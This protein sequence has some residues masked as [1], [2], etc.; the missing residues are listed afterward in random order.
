MY[1]KGT[2]VLTPFPFTDLSGTK[3]RPAVIISHNLRGDD[4]ML[5]F[6]TS[7][8]EKTGA[9][10]IPVKPN[11]YNGLRTTSRIL[12]DKIATVDKKIIL[13]ELGALHKDTVH[14][15]DTTLKKVLGMR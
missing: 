7:R 13:G 8:K 11:A 6:I 14:K 12:C 15:I 9:H 1:K 10:T 5:L 4:V 2:V 3:V